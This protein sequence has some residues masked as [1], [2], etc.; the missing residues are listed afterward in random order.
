MKGI[1]LILKGASD[2]SLGWEPNSHQMLP[3]ILIH[4][5]IAC[6]GRA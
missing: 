2:N 5:S 6:K 3:S 1:L 4:W